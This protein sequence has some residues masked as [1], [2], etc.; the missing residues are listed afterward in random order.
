MSAS[1]VLLVLGAGGNVGA[2]VV[3]LF[4]RNG[5]KVALA[6]RRLQDGTND[7]GHLHIHAD[8]ADEASVESAFDKTSA[9]FGPPSVVVYNAAAAHIVPADNPLDL[10]V[11]SFNQDIAVNTS[12]VLVAARRAVQ[13]FEQLP[14]TVPKTFVYTG[15]F[16]NTE[17]MP[18]LISLGIG[19]SASAHLIA[20]ASKAYGP[21]GYRFYYADERTGDGNAAFRDINGPFHAQHY[22]ELA[23]AEEQ[24]PW[25]QTFVGGQGYK[26]F[27]GVGIGSRV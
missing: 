23:E 1:K 25:L 14:S 20:V 27:S 8:L 15:N 24:R 22:L 6:A 18:F 19:K 10:S 17:V 4:A 11:A 26:D 7:D 13:D 9:K 5:Y 2:S 12:S 3:S 16:L 21:K